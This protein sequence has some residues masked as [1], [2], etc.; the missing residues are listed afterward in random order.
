MLFGTCMVSIV[1]LSNCPRMNPYG[2]SN[3]TSFTT[4]TSTCTSSVTSNRRHTTIVV[5]PPQATLTLTIF[6]TTTISRPPPPPRPTV[7]STV[8]ADEL[9]SPRLNLRRGSS[10]SV[11]A[12][13]NTPK[14]QGNGTASSSQIHDS[15]DSVSSMTCA[16]SGKSASLEAPSSFNITKSSSQTTLTTSHAKPQTASSSNT[17]GS[18]TTL[19]LKLNECMKPSSA[20]SVRIVTCL[21]TITHTVCPSKHPPITNQ[22]SSHTPTATRQVPVQIELFTE[23][24]TV[25]NTTT[26]PANVIT[27]SVYRAGAESNTTS[28]AESHPGQQK[29]STS[30]SS[31]P[32]ISNKSRPTHPIP[33]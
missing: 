22:T 11:S 7:T 30:T 26:L 9:P 20:Q 24:I 28:I 8:Y 27:M 17:S 1:K 31:S 15:I 29:W 19:S 21:E 33:P 4:I 32:S 6:V 13:P 2:R 25:Y 23:L 18:S 12:Y 10:S 5:T 3:I 16:S 14:V